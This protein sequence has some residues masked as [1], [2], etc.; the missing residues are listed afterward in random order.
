MNIVHLLIEQYPI[1]RSLHR[2]I[3]GDNLDRVHLHPLF[4]FLSYSLVEQRQ[5]FEEFAWKLFLEIPRS[6]NLLTDLQIILQ[7]TFISNYHFSQVIYLSQRLLIGNCL[8]LFVSYLNRVTSDGQPNRF[9]LL[10]Y[11]IYVDQG[12]TLLENLDDC[13]RMSLNTSRRNLLVKYLRQC[14]EK[15]EKLKFYCRRLIRQTLAL[16][17]HCQLNAVNLHFHLK[18]Y[19]LLSELHFLTF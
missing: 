17:I 4:D 3:L 19:I 11:L 15:P 6:E 2:A 5:D 10:L 9:S 13:F 16:P 12:L 14:R 1:D 8:S 7:N 18:M